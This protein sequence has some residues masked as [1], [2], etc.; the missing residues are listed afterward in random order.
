MYCTHVKKYVHVYTQDT[1]LTLFLV[2]VRETQCFEVGHKRT[3]V[4]GVRLGVHGHRSQREAHTLRKERSE[5]VKAT[6]L[7]ITAADLCS[8]SELV[9]VQRVQEGER[10]LSSG[11]THQHSV[12]VP[13]HAILLNGLQFVKD[14][15]HAHTQ[16][17]ELPYAV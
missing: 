6:P 9:L 17:T 5:G 2:E 16:V 3:R 13:H 14:F 1:L 4:I 10:V 8:G 11:E 7:A 15:T 12:A